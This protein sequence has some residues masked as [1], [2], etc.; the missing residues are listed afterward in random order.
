MYNVRVK[1][2]QLFK[3]FLPSLEFLLG[4]EGLLRKVTAQKC[5][6]EAGY[7]CHNDLVEE[8]RRLI[9]LSTEACLGIK[10]F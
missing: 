4:P 8:K 5:N 1:G 3:V 6:Q 7:H 10:R 2:L 9:C